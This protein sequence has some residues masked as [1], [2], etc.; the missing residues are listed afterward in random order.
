MDLMSHNTIIALRWADDVRLPPVGV[1]TAQR[2]DMICS[3]IAFAARCSM[4][5]A[6]RVKRYELFTKFFFSDGSVL[7]FDK[8]DF[9]PIDI[10]I[11][12]SLA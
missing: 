12:S 1:S 2:L 7:T 9:Y 6:V 5:L 11:N 4:R 10:I 3:D 8:F